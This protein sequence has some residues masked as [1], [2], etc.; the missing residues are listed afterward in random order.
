MEEKNGSGLQKGSRMQQKQPVMLQT[1]KKKL[2]LHVLVLLLLIYLVVFVKLGN[3]HM[4]LWDESMFAVNTYE[5]LQNGK[6]FSAYFD[7]APD[8]YNTKPL[9]TVW[10]QMISV[11]FFGFNELALR[12]PSALAAALSILALFIFMA[13]KYDYLWAWITAM[14]LLTSSGFITYHTAR[15]ADADSLLTLFLVMSNIYFINAITEGKRRNI[16]W[17]FLFMAL[18]FSTKMYA[19]LLFIPAWIIILIVQRKF[20]VFVFNK[21]FSAGLAGL[22]ILCVGPLIFREMDAPGY[23]RETLVK[24]AGRL[25]KVVERHQEPLTYYLDNFLLYRYATWFVLLIAGIVMTFLINAGKE[26]KLLGM[27]SLFILSYLIIITISTTKLEWYD[28]P[29]YPCFA[30]V[31]SYPLFRIIRH[32][33]PEN[34]ERSCYKIGLVCLCIFIYPYIMMVRSSQEN[35]LNAFEKMNEASERF[36]CESIHEGKNLDGLKVFHCGY[37]GAILF[38]K[39]KLAE[40]GQQ[41]EIVTN[42]VFQP[43]DQVLVSSDSLKASLVERY[44]FSRVDAFDNAEIIRIDS[45]LDRRP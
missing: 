29:L 38:Y 45:V 21:F 4:R 30:I 34:G 11:K 1:G 22:I 10:L 16:L 33:I 43:G 25:F 35:N 37:N 31:A 5:M 36:L 15:T 2:Y 3:F 26:K 32:F 40:E 24:D 41:L 12:L 14:I 44:R 9:L 13:R 8:L 20:K 7:G 28:M 17:F 6:F 39:Y 42:G 19:A 27:V 23:L 18:A